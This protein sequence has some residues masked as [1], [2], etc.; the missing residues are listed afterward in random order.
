MIIAEVGSNH[1]GDQVLAL[2]SV[3]AAREAG[4]DAVKF[5]LFRPETLVDA[6]FPVLK[7][8][9]GSERTQRDRFRITALSPDLVA[10]LA[11]AAAQQGLMFLATPFD[12]EAVD[13]LDPLQSA[14]K[15]ASGDLTNHPLIERVVAKGKP[16]MMSTGLSSLTEIEAAAALIPHDL[17]YP[18]HCVAAYPTPD[19]QVSLCTIPFLAEHFKRPVGYSDHTVGGLAAVAAVALGASIIEKHFMPS[20][21]VYVADKALSLG[22]AEFRLMANEI[23][24]VEKMRGAFAKIIQPD[25]AYFQ[26]ALR[27]SYYAKIDL[28]AGQPLREEWL[29]ALRPWSSEAACPSAPEEVIGRR[30]LRPVIA[31]NVIMRADLS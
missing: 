14:F 31:G 12:L 26:T 24:R 29:I 3:A 16:V 8:I 21:D 1:A 4:A 20:A 7:Y 15:I 11:E 18:L 10:R 30:L 19:E 25:E 17:F 9:Q 27:R 2:E 6:K 22:V 5:Q 23:R 28:P 13:I